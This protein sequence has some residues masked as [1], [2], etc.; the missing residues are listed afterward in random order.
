MPDIR[1]ICVASI[2]SSPDSVQ[3]FL[4]WAAA[5]NNQ[6]YYVVCKNQKDGDI[7]P[8]YDKSDQALLFRENHN[9]THVVVPALDRNT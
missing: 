1:F 4:N 8:D 9:P 3:S 6:V 7:F 5:L 2:T